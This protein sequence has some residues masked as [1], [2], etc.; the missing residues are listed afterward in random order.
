VEPPIHPIEGFYVEIEETIMAVKGVL[1]P[2]G[3]VIALPT[4]I[5]LDGGFRRIRRLEES[6]K[7]FIERY[8]EYYD[9]FD[10]AGRRL[11]APPL[12]AIDKVY[13]P[14]SMRRLRGIS[15]EAEELRRILIRESG[16]DE[17]FVGVTGSILL[18]RCSPKSDIDLIVYGIENGKRIYESMRRLRRSGRLLPLNDYY[19]LRKSRLDSSLPLKT[20]I[21]VERSKIL[22][23]MFSGKVYTAKIVPLPSEYWESLDQK[24]VEMGSAGFIGEVIDDKYSILTPNRYSVSVKRRL[25]GEVKE[26]EVIE[27]FSMRSR[28]AEA[29]SCGEW[30]KVV[31]RLEIIELDGMRRKRIFLGNDRDDVIIPLHYI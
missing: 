15:P 27:I 9:W 29:A 25:F 5:P 8:P 6:L 17:R 24:C 26:G 18:E 1:Q 28:F 10:F 19:D 22:A 14:L 2:P 30:V 20:W 4:Y 11:P 7:Y 21:S 13:N 23:G 16:V 31:G 12:D 3:R